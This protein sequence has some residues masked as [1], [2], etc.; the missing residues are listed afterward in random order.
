MLS[1]R[2]APNAFIDFWLE[3]TPEKATLYCKQHADDRPL[4]ECEKYAVLSILVTG[5]LQRHPGLPTTWGFRL[6]AERK[7]R[8]L[9]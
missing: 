9:Q 5:E 3:K 2:I 1:C 8:E 7:I 6:T 4:S